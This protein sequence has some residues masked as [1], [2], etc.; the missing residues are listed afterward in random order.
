MKQFLVLSLLFSL[1]LFCNEEAWTFTGPTYEDI[2]W[3]YSL[4]DLEKEQLN[5]QQKF[6][7]CTDSTEMTNIINKLSA[8]ERTIISKQEQKVKEL[9][10]YRQKV[11]TYSLEMLRNEQIVYKKSLAIDPKYVDPTRKETNALLEQYLI[12]LEGEIKKKEQAQC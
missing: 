8:V 3:S 7:G 4:P 6:A 11:K 12:I 1:N 10:N 5:L 2:L 9:D